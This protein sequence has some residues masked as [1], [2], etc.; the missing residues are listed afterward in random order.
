MDRKSF[1]AWAEEE[2][3]VRYRGR[4]VSGKDRHYR[5]VRCTKGMYL[6][7][8]AL[9]GGEYVSTSSLIRLHLGSERPMQRSPPLRW[10]RVSPCG[11]WTGWR[12]T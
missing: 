5:H 2:L 8:D 10:N 3:G 4:S 7:V 12:T 6:G 11:S 1:L 9:M